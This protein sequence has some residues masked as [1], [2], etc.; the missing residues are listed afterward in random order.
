[1]GSSIHQNQNVDLGYIT[2]Q[3]HQ[4]LI[5][6]SDS[7]SLLTQ[8]DSNQ[9]NLNPSETHIISEDNVWPELLICY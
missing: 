3:I 8:N 4:T 2:H 7:I 6:F 5:L 1:M 9:V